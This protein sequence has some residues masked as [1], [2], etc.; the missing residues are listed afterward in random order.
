[1]RDAFIEA[2]LQR[3]LDADGWVRRTLDDQ[4]CV[5]AIEVDAVGRDAAV[6]ARVEVYGAGHRQRVVD[7]V[8]E[9]SLSERVVYQLPVLHPVDRQALRLINSHNKKKVNSR[10]VHCE[11]RGTFDS[12]VTVQVG[13]FHGGCH[14]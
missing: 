3:Y 14:L 12:H 10:A 8:L 2:S 1:M 13:R 6:H 5:L 11:G 9:D 4:F 7:G